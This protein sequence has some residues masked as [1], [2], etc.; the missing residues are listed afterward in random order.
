M[1][2]FI[3]F[4]FKIPFLLQYFS[5]VVFMFV[6]EFLMGSMAFVF[7]ENLGHT[8]REELIDGLRY[9]YNITAKGPNS[10]V[11]IWDHLQSEFHCCG[12]K[13]YEDWYMI[14]AWPDK[15]WVPDSCCLPAVEFSH[16][17]IDHC[18]QSGNSELWFGRGCSDQ[19]HMWF[20]QRL[21]FIGI[22]CLVVAFIQL[23]GLISSMLLFCTVKHKRSSHTYKSY[24]TNWV[25]ICYSLS[26]EKD[27]AYI[28]YNLNN[29]APENELLLILKCYLLMFSL[30]I[31]VFIFCLYL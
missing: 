17:A 6:A 18:G 29:H 1:K 31:N 28:V 11:A 30:F 25:E 27:V 16:L 24:D 4:S 23:F 9:H 3:F 10:L 7:R 20:V 14:D 2:T 13:N 8:L 12:V 26:S 5:L 22:A 15:K 19:V 21:H